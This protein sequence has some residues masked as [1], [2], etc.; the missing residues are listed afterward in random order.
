MSENKGVAQWLNAIVNSL[1][2]C[3]EEKYNELINL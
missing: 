2:S 1:K 3:N